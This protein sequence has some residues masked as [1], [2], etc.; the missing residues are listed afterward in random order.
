VP[1]I[2]EFTFQHRD[3]GFAKRAHE[4][5]GGF[6][7]AGHNYGQGSSREQAAFAALYLG[8]RAVVAKSFARIHRTNLIAQAIVPLMFGDEADYDEVSQGHGWTIR[9]VAA[10]IRAGEE[11]LE[12]ETPHGPVRLDARFTERERAILVAGGL[13]AHTRGA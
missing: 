11:K 9:R 8:V 13:L 3:K 12:A 6:I 7:V 1:A 10:G 4:W 2:A 5:G